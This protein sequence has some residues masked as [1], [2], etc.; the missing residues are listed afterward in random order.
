[1]SCTCEQEREYVNYQA[2]FTKTGKEMLIDLLNWVNRESMTSMLRPN[3]TFFTRPTKLDDDEDMNTKIKFAR[4]VGFNIPQDTQ[5]IHYNRVD[6]NQVAK[7]QGFNFVLFLD[8]S[9]KYNTTHDLLDDFFKQAKVRLIEEDVV[10]EDIKID[11]AESSRRLKE[12]GD[13]FIDEYKED[14]I[15]PRLTLTMTD[16]SIAYYGKVTFQVRPRPININNVV[17]VKKLKPF[18]PPVKHGI[19]WYEDKKCN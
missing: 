13:D 15:Y 10:L 17:V 12:F 14:S 1:M 4:V 11:F 6:I 19:K 8:P 3:M 7:T 18:M 16:Y 2:D 9:K 5:E